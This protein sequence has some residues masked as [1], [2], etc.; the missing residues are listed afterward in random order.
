MYTRFGVGGL[1]SVIVINGEVM[2]PKHGMPV[3]CVVLVCAWIASSVL[4]QSSVLMR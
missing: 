1:A 2:K 4:A 3:V